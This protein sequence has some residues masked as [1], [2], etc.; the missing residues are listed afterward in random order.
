LFIIRAMASVDLPA[1]TAIEDGTLTPWSTAMLEQELQY[2]AGVRYVAVVE[3]LG[4][5]VGWCAARV[6]APEAELLKIAV[7]R[8]QRRQGIGGLLLAAL[9]EYLQGNGVRE[10]FLEVRAENLPAVLMYRR[11]GFST[12][13]KRP[14][15]YTEPKDDALLLRRGL[16]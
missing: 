16:G 6:I 8:E 2:R 1:V 9:I 11:Y 10:L 15:Y 7:H 3:N 5:V 14:G 4:R 13:G 12:V